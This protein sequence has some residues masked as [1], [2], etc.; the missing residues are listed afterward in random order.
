MMHRRS[1]DTVGWGITKQVRLL[2][3]IELERQHQD[4]P[5]FEGPLSLEVLFFFPL[6]LTPR[7]RCKARPG[8]QYT[9]P[10]SLFTLIHFLESVSHGVIYDCE[11]SIAYVTCK[12]T[13]DEE[14][15]TEF[16]ITEISR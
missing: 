11:S 13:Y 16:T 9:M 3:T 2:T 1:D 12:K 10:P 5:L 14:A 8:D 7:S 15:R 4:E 6:P